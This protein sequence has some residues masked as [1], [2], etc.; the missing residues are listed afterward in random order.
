MLVDLYVTLAASA[1]LLQTFAASIQ[2]FTLGLK[3]Q[4]RFPHVAHQLQVL[5]HKTQNRKLSHPFKRCHL[6]GMFVCF[7]C[8]PGRPLPARSSGSA[9][10][11]SAASAGPSGR[12]ARHAILNTHY[13]IMLKRGGGKRVAHSNIIS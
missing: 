11:L 10:K 2:F 3:L 7:R 9:A 1:V 8:I 5:G 6:C 12:W 4:E 13:C